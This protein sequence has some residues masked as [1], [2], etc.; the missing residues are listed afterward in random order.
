MLAELEKIINERINKTISREQKQVI[1]QLY[2]AGM[3]QAYFDVLEIISKIK[4]E[5]KNE[6][7]SQN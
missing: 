3:R 5:E 1:D 6:R 2:L 7:I 4:E